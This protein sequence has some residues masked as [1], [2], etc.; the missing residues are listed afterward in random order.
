MYNTGLLIDIRLRFFLM[1]FIKFC[2]STY[3]KSLKK[4]LLLKL[5]LKF[6]SLNFPL[7]MLIGLKDNHYYPHS[8]ISLEIFL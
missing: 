3:N 2:F 5:F 1:L 7:H 8:L 4:R 6:L